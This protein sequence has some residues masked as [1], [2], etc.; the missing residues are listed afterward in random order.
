MGASSIGAPLPEFHHEG[1]YGNH[2]F[3]VHCIQHDVRDGSRLCENACCLVAVTR[4]WVWAICRDGFCGSG[5]F[6]R[7]CGLS[8]RILG[9][10]RRCGRRRAQKDVGERLFCPH[11]CD[12]RGKAMMPNRKPQFLEVVFGQA[13]KVIELDVVVRERLCV[14]AET[15]S[16]EPLRNIFGHRD[17]FI[18][19]ARSGRISMCERWVSPSGQNVSCAQL[20]K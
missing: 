19:N 3:F 20:R 16:V 14:L 12:Q 10:M 9:S 15:K 4:L 8:G 2:W 13:G 1:R 17:R 5:D 6:C 7:R 11:R 18:P